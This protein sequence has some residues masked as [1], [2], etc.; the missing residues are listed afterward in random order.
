MCGKYGFKAS[1]TDFAT[2]SPPH[3]REIHN[4]NGLHTDASRI[5]PACAGN[6]LYTPRFPKIDR[7]HPRMCGKYITSM[8][9]STACVGSPPHVREILSIG[10]GNWNG[11]ED[12]P[13]MCGKYSVAPIFKCLYNRITPACAGN[14]SQNSAYVSSS[15]DHPRMCGKY[16][17]WQLLH[18][19]SKG[20][21]PH[22]RE[23]PQDVLYLLGSVRITPACA[24]NTDGWCRYINFYGDHPRMCGKYT[25]R[26]LYDA[27][28]NLRI[29]FFHSL[30][31]FQ[32]IS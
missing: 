31:N 11:T 20:S 10:T 25:K 6:T 9:S 4:W 16:F 19:L 28:C 22:V 23:I 18:R 14:T 2:G 3:V 12:H 8:V 13:R 24:G 30:L 27:T 7:D 17:S 5:T 29:P 1:N 26:S 32:F 21:P 15:R